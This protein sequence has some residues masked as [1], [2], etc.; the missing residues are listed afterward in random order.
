MT[1][2]TYNKDINGL[3]INIIDSTKDI[4]IIKYDFGD[5]DYS[6]FSDS[7]IEIPVLDKTSRKYTIDSKFEDGIYT[8]YLVY[9][10]GTYETIKIK[11][12]EVQE[13]IDYKIFNDKKPK[14]FTNK[15]TPLNI[16]RILE[17]SK[18]IGLIYSSSDNET[19]IKDILK[20]SKY[21]LIYTNI[22]NDNNL[23]IEDILEKNINVKNNVFN[24]KH[25]FTNNIS[26]NYV[27]AALI[28]DRRDCI[29]L[30]S[31][32]LNPILITNN[33]DVNISFSYK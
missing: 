29:I 11:L 20:G 18:K 24:L 32:F 1:K 21:E 2:I 33:L 16:D 10:D 6:Y 3:H 28:I 14:I 22:F 4:I 15:M 26:G 9:I 13:L 7:G 12:N 30:I 25:S 8:F 31:D 17:C 27:Y 19:Y 5:Y 23:I